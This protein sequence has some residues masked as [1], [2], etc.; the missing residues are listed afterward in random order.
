MS[1]LEAALAELAVTV[2][3]S[4]SAPVAVAGSGG[5]TCRVHNVTQDTVGR[6]VKAMVATAQDGDRLRV[7]GLCIGAV[8]IDRDLA[9][10]GVGGNARLSAGGRGRVLRVRSGVEVTLRELVI[11]DG[12]A[13]SAGGIL[14]AGTL[15]LFH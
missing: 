6:S 5:S 1:R 14:N 8:D 2:L 10:T 9:I 15:S 7:Q 13:R 12:A 3:A 4:L 11:S